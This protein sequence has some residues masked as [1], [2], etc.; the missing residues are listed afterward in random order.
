MINWTGQLLPVKAISE[1]VKKK[2]PKIKV[3]VMRR[4]PLHKLPTKSPI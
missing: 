2:N 4:I 3:V 1:A